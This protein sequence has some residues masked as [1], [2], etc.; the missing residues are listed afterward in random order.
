M[1]ALGAAALL[2]RRARTEAAFLLLLFALIATTSFLFAA[3]PRL[4]NRTADEGVSYALAATPQLERDIRLNATG[5][6]WPGDGGGV[7][8]VQA[9]GE[10]REAELPSSV[11]GLIS[12]RY[13]GVSSVRLAVERSIV[14]VALRYQDGVPESTQ[15]VSGRWPVDLGM[16]LRPTEPGQGPGPIVSPQRIKF[17]ANPPEPPVVIEA[18]LSTTAAEAIDAAVGDRLSVILDRSDSLLPRTAYGIA[19]TEIEIVG[20]FE[21]TDP[22]AAQW[23]TGGLLEPAFRLGPGGVEAINVAAFVSPDAYSSIHAGNLPFRYEWHLQTDPGRLDAGQVATVQDDLRQM[24]LIASSEDDRRLPDLS[25]FVVLRD[26]S[27]TSGL[28]GVLDQ[29]ATQRAL[30][31]SV[32]VI[33]ALGPLFLA[34]AA[35]GMLAIMLVR[36]RRSSILLARGRGA[37]GALLLGVGLAEAILLA[38][39]AAL[40]GFLL[41]VSAVP[42]RDTSTSAILAL[43]VAAGACLLLVAATWPAAQRPLIQLDRDDPPV[44]RVPA[45]R[46]VIEATIVGVAVLALVLLQQRGLSFS[47]GGGAAQSDPLLAAVPLLTGLAAGII[48]LRLYPLP[49]RALGWLAARRRDFVPVVG[50][51][52][53]ARHPSI[54][55]LPLLVL[56]LTAA[57]GAFA[58]VIGTSVDRGQVAASYLDVGADYRLEAAAI[59]GL[60]SELDPTTVDGIEAAASGAVVP[61]A[62]LLWEPNQRSTIA[63]QAVDAASYAAVTA[64]T[65]ADPAWPRAFLPSPS[66]PD[67]GTEDN[68]IPALASADFPPG[69]ADVEPGDTFTLE[70]AGQPLVFQLLQ[71]RAGLPGLGQAANFVMAPMEW[72]TAAAPALS[73]APSVMWLRG[74]EDAAAPLATLAGAAAR[75]TR[76]VSRQDAYELVHEAPLGTAVADGFAIGL[77][78]AVLYLAIILIGA[79][80][81]SA[82]GHTRDLAYLRTLGVSTRQA[83][84]LTAVEHAPPLLVA[85]IPG[86]L[87]GVAVASLVEPGLGLA[88]FTGAQSVPLFVDWPTLGLVI[89]ALSAVV[90]IAIGAG[91]FLATRTRLVS[92]LRMED[93]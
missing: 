76:I 13:M 38:G 54:A 44:L 82:A 19:P 29:F 53:V 28:L 46:L 26:V 65:V 16:P 20:L 69:R 30:S 4:L 18:A 86:V 27:F 85:L 72:V 31:E 93:G 81:V 41:A 58:S 6:I 88:Q 57:F 87:L 83:M 25:S 79:V 39:S 36:R 48:L 5:Q 3:G 68:P 92:A 64:G 32:L 12:D 91:T 24:S 55:N 10:E 66:A 61:R 63:L 15:L 67:I 22:E 49:I 77:G 84:G 21:P 78:V 40:V 52:T 23:A 90:V 42:A 47:S 17:F 37:S 70:V 75:E 59:G 89:V 34:G 62:F 8:A 33:A 45:R 50:L 7:S 2:M 60:P 1:R 51:R 14:A 80:I 35:I 71:R 74:S 56:M 43:C 9:Y 73:L 11:R